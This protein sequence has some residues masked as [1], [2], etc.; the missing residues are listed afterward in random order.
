MRTWKKMRRSW[1]RMSIGLKL[2][3]GASVIL[4]LSIVGVL[5]AERFDSASQ[6]DAVQT[7]AGRDAEKS[8]DD[9]KAAG[10][11]LDLGTVA[12]LSSNYRVAVTE[13]SRYEASTGQLIVATVDATYIGKE[14]GEPWSDLMAEFSRPGSPTFDESGCPFDLGDLDPADQTTL[15]N[16]DK[17]TYG[18]CIDVPDVDL[19][20][21]RVTVEEAFSKGDRI[22]WSTKVVVTKEAPSA[23]PTSSAGQAPGTG[24]QRS[25]PYR[26]PNNDRSDNDAC[27]DFD[28]D[29]FDRYKK[30]G[31]GVKDTYRKWRDNGGDDEDKIDDYEE[32]EEEYDKQIDLYE[33]WADEC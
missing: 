20:S 30:W 7:G 33:Q 8:G 29:K 19:K 10:K 32:W 15:K 18:V 17:A 24:P 11:A 27:E 31:D 4:A 13:I 9:V 3:I 5:A 28:E 22:S 12:K 26:Q 14:D 1:R 16:G 25:Q 21:G 6:D 23:A 2:S